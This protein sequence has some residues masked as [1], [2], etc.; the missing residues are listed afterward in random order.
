[1][2]SS[3]RDQLL[4][5]GLVTP[6]QAKQAAQQQ[7]QRPASRHQAK[8]PSETGSAAEQRQLAK[9]AHD[10]ELNRRQQEK[11]AAK[12]RRQQLRQL[13]EQCR[14]PPLESDDYFNFVDGTTLRRIAVDADLH[15]R[16]IQGKVL[17]VRYDNRYALVPDTAIARIREHDERAIVP[18]NLAPSTPGE[19][20]PY[21]DFVVPDDLRW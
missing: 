8:P 2:N 9:A 15:E 3:L 18:L 1:M 4:A 5:A 7:Q 6:K 21:K 11:A 14:L 19:D 12:A 20:D 17:I 10:R 13:V 16:L